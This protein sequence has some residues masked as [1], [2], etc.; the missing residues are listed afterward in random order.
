MS[1]QYRFDKNTQ[2]LHVLCTA[3]PSLELLQQ[4]LLDVTR[5]EEYP[6]DV[7][8]LWDCR[9]ADFNALDRDIE[10]QIIALRAS[11]PERGQAKIAIVVT[12][13][14]NFGLTRMYELKSSDLPQRMGV[15]RG[16]EEAESWLRME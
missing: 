3:Q 16:V 5:S 13:E 7:S 11:F 8:I 1:I 9:K 4:S 15:F 6:P 12:G 10:E 2:I 14:L